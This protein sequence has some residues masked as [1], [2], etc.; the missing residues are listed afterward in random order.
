M[1][2]WTLGAKK[3]T[4][5]AD[6]PRTKYSWFQS[7]TSRAGNSRKTSEK[8]ERRPATPSAVVFLCLA[9]STTPPF[10]SRY[11]FLQKKGHS[12]TQNIS[13]YVIFME[14]I[15]KKT[16]MWWELESLECGTGGCLGC[17]W[18]GG[19][20]R[21][22]CATTSAH[23]THPPTLNTH[24]TTIGFDKMKQRTRVAK[25]LCS[26]GNRDGGSPGIFCIEDGHLKKQFFLTTAYYS[27]LF[28][29]MIFSING[30][31]LAARQN[32]W[33]K[34]LIPKLFPF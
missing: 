22:T 6:L 30:F 9:G 19:W 16:T 14:E 24:Q 17:H 12:A 4:W 2:F 21:L 32:G 3:R 20:V 10:G 7:P 5:F 34:A 28:W 8:W 11:N 26:G 33:Q 1:D 18:S 15:S 25:W 23:H 13:L 27:V 31:W 29:Q